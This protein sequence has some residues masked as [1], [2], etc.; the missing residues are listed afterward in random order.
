MKIGISSCVLGGEK[1]F[2][3]FGGGSSFAHS[4]HTLETLDDLGIK[5]STIAGSQ[6]GR[7]IIGAALMPLGCLE[8][9]SR[10]RIQ[11]T[12]CTER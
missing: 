1:G 4:R 7:V 11:Q 10:Q 6:V 3:G 9:K 2:A 12:P 8:R 5:P